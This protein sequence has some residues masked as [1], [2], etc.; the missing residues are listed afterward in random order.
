[1]DCIREAENYLRYYRELTKSVEH[2][3]RMIG[4]LTWQTAPKTLGVVTMDVTGVRVSQSHDTLTQIFQLQKWQEMRELTLIEMAK[5]EDVLNSICQDPGCERYRDVLV[6][7]YVEKMEKED[8]ARSI[9]YSETSR[10]I[11][12][13]MKTDAIR[14]FSVALFGV[15]ALKAI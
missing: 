15:T 14:K 5:V 7:W 9:G 13:E 12:Y 3:D 11:V 1:M 10:R 2:A 4:Q 8:I 6:M